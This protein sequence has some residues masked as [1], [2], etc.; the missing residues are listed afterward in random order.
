VPLQGFGA[1][2]ESFCLDGSTL[3]LP[4]PEEEAFA[5]ALSV[6]SSTM[7]TV[8]GNEHGTYRRS[9]LDPVSHPLVEYGLGRL[10][11]VQV[12]DSD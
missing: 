12:T 11:V 7:R 4:P 3:T 10:K 6:L 8:G 5:V 9:N 2:D 1:I